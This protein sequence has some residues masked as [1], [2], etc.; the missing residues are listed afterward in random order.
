MNRLTINL[1]ERGELPAHSY[2]YYQVRELQG[3]QVA[4]IECDEDPELMMQSVSLQLRHRIHWQITQAGPPSW[5]VEVQAREN[6]EAN[7]LIDLLSR[8]HERLDKLFANALHRVNAGDVASAA[9]YLK[10]F[11]EGLQRH[12]HA[13]D[14]I[15]APSF[16]GPVDPHGMDPTSTMQ[17][18]HKQIQEQLL[19]IESFFE[20]D[21]LPES[22]QVAPYF[23]LL[24]G[25]LAK[26]ETREELN[27]FPNW[28]RALLHFND[29]AAKQALLTRIHGILLGKA[30]E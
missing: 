17:R 27:L 6:V 8:D 24:S 25:T 22:S 28:D 12:M 7:S 16:Q 13:E 29:S 2:I 11:S 14:D 23:G 20:S 3:G 26:H 19:I 18:E 30:P 1:Q 5:L 4:S 21:Q 9:N 10:A 15:L